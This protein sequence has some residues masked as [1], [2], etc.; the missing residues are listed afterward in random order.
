MDLSLIV[1]DEEILREAA[2]PAEDS[3]WDSSA[4]PLRR[5]KSSWKKKFVNYLKGKFCFCI[6]TFLSI[7][8]ALVVVEEEE[9]L[10]VVC[11]MAFSLSRATG[12]LFAPRAQ[13]QIPGCRH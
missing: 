4:V 1:S 12:W 2:L 11:G 7:L 13:C 6:E 10:G 9:A 5:Q 3:T 8:M